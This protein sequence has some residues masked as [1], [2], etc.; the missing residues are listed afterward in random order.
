MDEINEEEKFDEI[1]LKNL[2][3]IVRFFFGLVSQV[4]VAASI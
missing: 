4:L 1:E 3:S 2:L